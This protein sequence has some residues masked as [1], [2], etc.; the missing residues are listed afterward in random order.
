MILFW[1]VLAT[2]VCVALLFVVPPLLSG[3]RASGPARD[4]V[5]IAIYRERLKELE[6]DLKNGT[7]S[8]EQFD[9]TREELER[10]L[11]QD[12]SGAPAR[13]SA[14]GPAPARWSAAVVA[15][16]LPLLAV[17]WYL[18]LGRYDAPSMQGRSDIPGVR[19]P[20]VPGMPSIEQMVSGLAARLKNNPNDPQGWS[21]L[22][23]SY[24]VLK[25]YPEAV[26]AYA[27]AYGLRADDAQLLADYAEALALASKGRLAGRPAELALEALK[28]QPEQQKA[29]W[30]AGIAAVQQGDASQA[31][32]Y[33]QRLLRLLP[34][35]GEDAKMVEGALAQ[36]EG[37]AVA[38]GGAPAGG[39]TEQEATPAGGAVQVRVALAPGLVNKASPDDTLFIFAR[40]INGPRM[41]L[42]VVRK[43]VKD[44]PVTVTLDDSMAMMPSMKLS[45]F[46]EVALEAHIS[47]SGNA[48]PQTGDLLGRT[49]ST[50][51]GSQH[52]V[53]MTIDHLVQDAQAAA[54]PGS[55]AA[56]SIPAGPVQESPA[57]EKGTPKLA[58]GPEKPAQEQTAENAAGGSPPKAGAVPGGLRV[59]VALAPRLAGKVSP[60]DALFVYARAVQGPRMPLAITR[61]QVKDL[62]LTVTLDDSMAMMPAM[63]MSNFPEVV[64]G[65]RVSKSGNAMPQSGDLQGL[66]P[67]VRVGTAA[68]VEVTIDTLIP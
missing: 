45:N 10:A 14:A 35:D 13:D 68:P 59:S 1:A 23:R 31:K 48:M 53:E 29:L 43:R 5:N 4:E 50:K 41:P 16:A 49:P 2:M 51:V 20:A 28:L 8:R 42:A 22:G 24:V 58:G 60:E 17:G 36:A 27:K 32:L 52:V 55:G 18:G 30:L 37:Q 67:S 25:R 34:K 63:R 46:P 57:Q 62:P 33:W 3:N 21:M 47:K 6:S 7:L 19:Q 15:V 12:V 39:S 64:V 40:A 66:S 44:L 56:P 65:A 54:P 61:K 26:D 11:L 9:K 38:G